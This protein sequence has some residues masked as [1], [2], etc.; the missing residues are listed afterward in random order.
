VHAGWYPRC[1]FVGLHP[2]E[3]PL[4]DDADMPEVRAGW[5]PRGYSRS[6]ACSAP[7]SRVDLRYSSGAAAGLR[8]RV[9]GGELLGLAGFMPEG[10]VMLR[11]PEAPRRV[12][13]FLREHELD[14]DL[15]LHTL[16]LEPDDRR[17]TTLWAARAR[18]GVELPLR[19]PELDAVS[20]DPHEDVTALLDGQVVPHHAEALQ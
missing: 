10:E 19:L 2:P 3:R 9:R 20:F 11:L 13:V 4:D 18:T 14:V 17:L 1:A 5:I 12:R 15:A 16:L 8:W 6:V 7:E